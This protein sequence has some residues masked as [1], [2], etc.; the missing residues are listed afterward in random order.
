MQSQQHKVDVLERHLE[1]AEQANPLFPVFL[2]LEHLRLLII[3]AG[4]VGLEKISAV[5][6]NAPATRI[7][8]VA[9]E[10]SPAFRRYVEHYPNVQVVDKAYQPSDL[11]AV[12]LAIVATGNLLLDEQIR[13]DASAKGKLINVA[14]TPTL[15]D[16]YLGSIVRKGSLKIAISTNGKSP[17][18][19]KRLKTVLKDGL[20]DS[21]ET[22]LDNLQK[23]RMQLEGDFQYKVQHLNEL[24][25]GL[26]NPLPK[27]EVSKPRVLKSSFW[28]KAGLF[29]LAFIA[30]MLFGYWLFGYVL[31]VGWVNRSFDYLSG[32][33]NEQFVW[34]FAAGFCAQLVDGAMGMGY[35]VLSTTFLLSSNLPIPIAGISSSVHMAEMFS[36]GTAGISHYKYKHVN[37][38]LWVALVIPGAI[39]AILGALFIG[40]MGKEFGHILRPLI[41][42]YT[43][44]LGFKIVMK[45]FKNL[46]QQRHRK[47]V[48]VRPVAFIGGFLDAFGGGW[49]PLVTSTLISGGRDPLYTIGSSTF[50]KFFTSIGSTA[51]FIIV[52]GQMHFQVI[53]G[54]IFGGMLAAPFAARL[55]GKLPIKTMYICV[56]I[57]VILCS[58]RVLWGVF[59]P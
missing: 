53:A 50:T 30:T 52:F 21:L 37:K 57:L 9:L 32:N 36:V 18:M 26:V 6:T 41:S 5:L 4:N 34:M 44:Y 8:V 39:G 22:S 7:T 48:N 43:F 13:Q 19:A 42:I 1:T 47:I 46:R 23:I 55:S 31:P 17:T 10:V 12:D 54:L 51:T 59:M 40:T 49:G 33:L 20:P 56:G 15:C 38:K 24:T 45:A 14:D 11:E 2:K 25:Q 27:N 28:K 3:G 16:F 29:A 58:L 35:G